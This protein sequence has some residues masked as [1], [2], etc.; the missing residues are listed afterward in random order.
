MRRKKKRR[1]R[2]R[3]TNRDRPKLRRFSLSR[4]VAFFPGERIEEMNAQPD[5][6]EKGISKPTEGEECDS[7]VTEGAKDNRNDTSDGKPK[8]RVL[9]PVLI[10]GAILVIGILFLLHVKGKKNPAP[11]GGEAV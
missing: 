9:V 4:R 8:R 5:E 1:S 11:Q 2:R 7:L 10:V 6:S 3:A